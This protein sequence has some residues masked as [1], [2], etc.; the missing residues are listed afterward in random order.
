VNLDLRK[1]WRIGS[2]ESPWSPASPQS[3]P[4]ISPVTCPF[5]I[6]DVPKGDRPRADSR[7]Q[8]PGA[9]FLRSII[10]VYG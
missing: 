2:R 3:L 6:A 5:Q 10:A 8:T 4:M 1:S 7:T 9:P